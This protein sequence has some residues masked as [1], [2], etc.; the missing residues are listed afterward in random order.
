M[1]RLNLFLISLLAAVVNGL[2]LQPFGAT[3]QVGLV[4]SDV[5]D[6]DSSIVQ[7]ANLEAG[8]LVKPPAEENSH[9]VTTSN[10]QEDDDQIV[11]FSESEAWWAGLFAGAVETVIQMPVITA[12]ICFQEGRDLPR[13]LGLYRGLGSQ[14]WGKAMVE[15]NNLTNNIFLFE[16]L[17][18]NLV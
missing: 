7:P 4:G 10:Y 15:Q 11:L 14:V 8:R 6:D 18:Q 9:I 16:I 2:Q 5:P 3:K 17:E 12:K 13:G 1:A